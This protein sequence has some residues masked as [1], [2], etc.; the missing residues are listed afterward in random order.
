MGDVRQRKGSW[1]EPMKEEEPVDLW[2]QGPSLRACVPS[3]TWGLSRAMPSF[4]GLARE[5][6]RNSLRKSPLLRIQSPKIYSWESAIIEA[7]L[8]LTF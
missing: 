8:V 3:T 5:R 1:R 7:A 2:V 6:M 4:P